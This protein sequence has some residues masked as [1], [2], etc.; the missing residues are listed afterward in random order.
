MM[1]T[2]VQRRCDVARVINDGLWRSTARGLVVA[3]L[4]GEPSPEMEM[5]R[6]RKNRVYLRIIF[7]EAAAFF[8]IVEIS[9]GFFRVVDGIF[10]LV[11]DVL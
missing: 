5:G 1:T 9:L 8:S 2:S 3:K 10:S 11:E 4:G 6:R 7:W